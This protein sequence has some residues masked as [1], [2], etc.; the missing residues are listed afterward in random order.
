MNKLTN[1][2][3]YRFKKKDAFGNEYFINTVPDEISKDF[4]K[5]R[6]DHRHH[7]LDALVIALATKD[8]INYLNNQN[9]KKPEKRFDLKKKLSFK[10]KKD[11]YGN[12]QWQ[13]YKPWETLTQDSR[14]ALEKII[15]SFKKDKRVINK[16]T[17]YYN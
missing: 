6:L 11:A 4:S 13:Y 10:T 17:N 9:A 1:S 2:K 12:S 5:K 16:A 15:V 3:Q 7:A 8:H 14:D